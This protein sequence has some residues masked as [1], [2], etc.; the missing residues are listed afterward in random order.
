MT[1][2]KKYNRL[3]STAIWIESED[4][5]EKEVIV[6]FGKK[7]LIISDSNDTPLAHWSLTST[8]IISKNIHRVI[9]SPDPEGIERL[10]VKDEEM[11]N[12]IEIFISNTKKYKKNFTP[13]IGLIPTIAVLILIGVYW[14]DL[15]IYLIPLISNAQEKQIL[16]TSF[17]SHKKNYG[18]ICSSV[19]ADKAIDELLDSLGEPYKNIKIIVLSNQI[20]DIIH[21]PSGTLM[22]S[23]KFLS[24]TKNSQ[25]LISILSQ[26]N[27]EKNK[28]IPLKRIIEQ[29]SMFD[30]FSFVLGL[31]NSLKIKS[32]NE[33]E[34]FSRRKTINKEINLS[35][36]SWVAIQNICFN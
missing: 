8:R 19:S 9:F 25:E 7:T 2:L 30:I 28:R 6:A 24:K 5:K 15:K 26:V 17:E 29:N 11:I 16:R 35:D 20:V 1:A 18:P 31:K 21:F 32:L 10:I 33:L 14:K 27:F 4:K 12:S 23:K 34:M 3:E 36:H 13:L 22:I